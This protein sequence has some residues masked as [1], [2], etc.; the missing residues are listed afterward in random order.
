MGMYD[1]RIAKAVMDKIA[2]KLADE[3]KK[4]EDEFKRMGE[5]INSL[6]KRIEKLEDGNNTQR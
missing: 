3:F 5:A 2:D 4:I 1:E 6:E